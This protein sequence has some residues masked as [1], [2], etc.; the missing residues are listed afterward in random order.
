MEDVEEELM[1]EPSL[2]QLGEVKTKT[3]KPLE[4]RRMC[5]LL[6]QDSRKLILHTEVL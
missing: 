3:V 1:K 2:R 6:K 4:G 5:L